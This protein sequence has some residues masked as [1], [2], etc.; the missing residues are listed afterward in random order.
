MRVLIDTDPGVDDAMALLLAAAS[1]E[2][3]IVGVTTVFGN[4][5]DVSLLTRNALA[6]LELAGRSDVPVAAGAA[7][8]LVERAHPVGQSVHGD[9]GLGGALMS[10]PQRAAVEQDAATFLVEKARACAGALTL[11]TLGPQTNVARARALE[12]SLPRLAPSLSMMGGAAL[13][14]GNCTP[15]AESNIYNDP[16]AARDTFASGAEIIM[17]GL[18]VTRKAPVGAD[19]LDEL[20]A[21]GNR[22]G[23]FLHAAAQHYLR[24]YLARGE[25]GLVMHDV[26]AIMVLLR[27]EIYT[28]RRVC[29]DV[30]TEGRLTLGAT[31]ADL[32][33]HWGRTPQTTLLVDVD[34]AE[35]R[36]EFKRRIARLP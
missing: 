28:T 36:S 19:F 15:A 3:E 8:P 6:I 14:P 30:E 31:V 11:V 34:A 35:F 5:R 20:R 12:P 13:V 10:A 33:G 23:V 24:F 29:I 2:L 18:D 22:A 1:P 16:E 32:E 27:P 21:L 17:A 4:N 9:N 26:H 25:P 7:R